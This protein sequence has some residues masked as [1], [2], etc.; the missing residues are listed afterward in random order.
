VIEDNPV[1]KDGD[2]VGEDAIERIRVIYSNSAF[3][4]EGKVMR[5]EYDQTSPNK[6]WWKP[7]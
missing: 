5:L 3:G 7:R 2:T 6:P 1:I 4:Q